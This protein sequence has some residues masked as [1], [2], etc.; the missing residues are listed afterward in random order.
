MIPARMQAGAS[1]WIFPNQLS[2][3]KLWLDGVDTST[4]TKT[5]QN[6]TPTGSG[7]SGST[8]IT[9]SAS[10]AALAQVGNEIRIGGTD[11][12]TISAISTV[13]I[14]TAETLTS[15]YSAGSVL[16]LDKIS[17]LTDKSGSSNTAT[18]ATADSQPSFVPSIKNTKNG[19]GFDGINDA[20]AIASSASMDNIFGT[21]GSQIFVI[22][23]RGNGGGGNGRLCE[24]TYQ[25]IVSGL[26]GGNF[27]FIFTQ[28]TSGADWQWT[29]ASR[30]IAQ[31]GYS[32]VIITYNAATASTAPQVYINSSSNTS[33][34]VTGT[35]SSTATSDAGVQYT[36]GNRTALDRAYNGLIM[37]AI[38]YKR[39]L[40]AA[41]I[42]QV[43][44][45]LA[46]KWK[47][48]VG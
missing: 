37:E 21:G 26:S 3:L 14:T 41:E 24:K 27:N 20:F 11:I 46:N 35:G 17:Q 16:A 7:T 32:I 40:S 29:T 43:L 45:Y 34:N 18:Q 1:S 30:L 10:M 28:P 25:M 12:Y 42:R 38:A 2:D 4:I 8:T 44:L 5:Y 13:T 36:L 23:P 6:I 22:N 33:L 15:N 31:N 9:A 48:V 39:I 47:I 19:I